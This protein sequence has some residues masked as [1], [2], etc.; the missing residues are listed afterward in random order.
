VTLQTNGL[1]SVNEV[2]DTSWLGKHN[3]TFLGYLSDFDPSALYAYPI[4]LTVEI[5]IQDPA[6]LIDSGVA[7]E[8]LGSNTRRPPVSTSGMESLFIS[9]FNK[10]SDFTLSF[11]DPLVLGITQ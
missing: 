5:E 1:L 7:A 4:E 9:S 10:T 6:S 3:V 11:A 8:I 2:E